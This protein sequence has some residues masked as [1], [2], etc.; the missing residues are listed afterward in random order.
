MWPSSARSEQIAGLRMPP[1]FIG[2]RPSRLAENTSATH[3]ELGTRVVFF[4][5]IVPV[6]TRRL[7]PHGHEAAGR[8]APVRRRSLARLWGN[9]P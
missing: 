2:S 8:L 6:R 7:H 9:E 5:R 3:G 1:F 4:P